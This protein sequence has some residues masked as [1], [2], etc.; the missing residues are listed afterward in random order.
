MIHEVVEY[1]YWGT[2]AVFV[3]KEK[4][5]ITRIPPV[6]K[7]VSLPCLHWVTTEYRGKPCPECGKDPMPRFAL[8]K[9]PATRLVGVSTIGAY[10]YGRLP[11]PPAAVHAPAGPYPLDAHDQYGDC[12]IAGVAHLIA[13]WNAEVKENDPVPRASSVVET[14]FSLTGGEDT[15]LNEQVVL[16]AWR[17]DGLFGEKIAAYAPVNHQN[18]VELH[19]TI[20]FFGGAY[21][22]IQCPASAQEQF[23]AGRPW[24]YVPGS[25]VDGG[26]C[27]A[28][29][30]YTATAL[31]CATWGG[32]AEV[33]YSFLSHFLDEA[34]AVIPHQFVE[35]GKDGPGIDVATLQHDLDALAA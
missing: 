33:T 14:Y 3:F 11:A 13:A 19:Q 31:L 2:P 4:H 10:A 17:T 7:T 23:A 22:G 8:G 12:T 6:R 20:A 34:W 1:D 30:G 24:T 25:P 18:I 5:P 27:I 9:L 29:I 32:V 26:H 15:G 35:R 28:A 21:L 16:E